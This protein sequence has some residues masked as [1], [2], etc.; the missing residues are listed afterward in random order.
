MVEG[1]AGIGKTTTWL[2]A[3]ERSQELGFRVL[4]TRAMFAESVLAYSSLAGLLHGLNDD[5]FVDLPHPQRNAID[6]VLLRVSA[7]GEVTD[8]RAVAA[9]VLS[10]IERLAEDS[11]VLVA[12]D[13]L[14]WLDLPS[15]HIVSSVAQ[16]LVGPVGVLATLRTGPDA[17]EVRLAM[18]LREPDRLRRLRVSPLSL[19]ALHK[20]L[21]ERLGRSFPRPKMLQIHGVSGG[22]PF[23][24]LELARAMDHESAHAGASLPDTLAGLVRARIG[25]LTADARQALL[26]A[27]CVPDPSVE[28]IARALNTGAERIA[29]VLEEAENKGIVEIAGQ[30]I[31]FAHPL[32]IRGVYGDA[33]P[34]RRREMHRRLA[35]VIDEP[36]LK[37]RH[38]ALAATTGDLLTLDSLDTA[39][40]LARVRGAPIAAAELLELAIGLGGDTPER[41]IRL[42][43]YCFNSGDGARARVLLEGVVSGPAPPTLRGEAMSLLAVMSQLEGSLLEAAD[44]LE[45][46]LDDAGDNGQ[47]R[48]WILVSLAW[49]QIHIGHHDG[50]A[51]SI[52]R[53]RH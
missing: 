15:A 53:R 34:A 19:G 51:K 8:Q 26:A 6:R 14:Q 28:L 13:D 46:A 21:F 39:A 49:V 20:M 30:G 10:V 47:L 23:Y 48:A 29:M 9:A 33:A 17:G 32:L 22:N 2:A 3:L 42:A 35:E 52:R 40:E 44:L 36:E 7:D 38:L 50:S 45:R 25:S 18:E 31:S 4:S 12:I 24:A 37:A 1:E 41:R 5:V 16:R 43:G 27:A 11:P